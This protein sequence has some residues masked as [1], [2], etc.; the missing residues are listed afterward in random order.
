MKNFD[1]D[2]IKTLKLTTNAQ[3]PFTNLRFYLVTHLRFV[4]RFRTLKKLKKQ[5]KTIQYC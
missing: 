2:I 4:T 3:L 1:E 5:N